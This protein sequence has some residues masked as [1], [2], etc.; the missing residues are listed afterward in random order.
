MNWV[1]MP[2]GSR[3]VWANWYDRSLGYSEPTGEEQCA[4]V[5]MDG[6]KWGSR[7]CL[8]RLTFVCEIGQCS[9]VV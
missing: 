1:W 2:S 5:W 8:S 6:G 4:R 7:N 9:K 3:L